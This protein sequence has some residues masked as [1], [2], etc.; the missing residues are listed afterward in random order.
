VANPIEE[1]RAAGQSVWLDFIRRGLIRSGE[2]QRMVRA[3]WVQGV[4]S[5]PTIFQKAIAGSTDYDAAFKR[6]AEDKLSPYE[7]FLEIGGEDI[8]MAADVLRPVYDETGGGDG[9]VSFEAQAG[10]TE[11]MLAEARRMWQVVGRPNVMIKIPGVPEGVA[12]VEELVFE[13][14]NVNITLLFDVEVYERFAEAYIRGLERRLEAGRRPDTIASVAS[15]FVSRV[16]AKVDKLLPEGSPLR[17]KVAIA[18]ARRAYRRFLDRFY[19]PR[20]ERLAQTGALVQRPLWASTGTK[21]PEYSD[22]MYVEELVAPDTVNTMPEATLQAFLD[23]GKVRPAVLEGLDDA[24][25]VLRQ[26]EAAGIDL[27]KI[28]G[29]LL[30]EGLAS[31]KADF[32][33]LLAEIEKA[34]REE[35][36]ELAAT[37]GSVVAG[38]DLSIALAARTA[39]LERAEVIARIWRC[40]HRVWKQ[41]PTEITQPNRLGWLT[42]MDQMADELDD[43]QRFAGEVRSDGLKTAVVL[44]MGGSSLAPEVLHATFG[45]KNGGLELRVLDT[46]VPEDILALEREIDPDRTLFIVASKSGTTLET[47][48]QFAYFWDRLPKGRHYV[49][50][51]DPGTP[52]DSLAREKGFRRTFLN[53]DCLGGRHSALSYVGLVP[54]ALIGADLETLIDGAQEMRHACHYCVPATENPGAWLG[55]ILGEAAPRG[56]DKLT[57]VLPDEVASLGDWIEQLI[58]ESTGKEGKGIVPVVGE[59]LGPP[60]V[61]GPDRLFVSLGDNAALQ[62]L[63]AAGHPVVRLPYHGPEQLGAE[64]FRWMF[65]TAVAGHI[66]RINPFDQ[67]DVQRAKDAAARML[68]EGPLE[69]PQTRSVL[70][71]LQLIRPG[72]YA[73][74]LAYLP[75]RAEVRERLDA[76]RLKLRDRFH[77]ATTVGFGPRYLHSTGQLHKGG[78][79]TGVFFQLLDDDKEDAPIP[80]RPY[81]FA[82]LKRAQADGDLDA[83]LALGRRAA[84]TKLEHLEEA[85]R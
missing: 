24:E 53:P 46:T 6:L 22:V 65:A 51:T 76:L 37:R 77:I 62:P 50:I 28:G 66:L 56:Q 42:I 49:A 68:E 83:L 48:S 63:E 14:I 35:A 4:T 79:N 67:P 9:F 55:A 73:A 19:G 29:E 17:G 2:L 12:A 36:L 78:P 10:T 13:G 16:D 54:A 59:R 32:D 61:Y 69:Q 52:L 58:A 26:A 84:R 1:L 47:Q 3:G 8:R 21:N 43:L 15:F 18:N 74:L 27:Q 23:H 80:G 71:L 33:K 31:F 70:E 45:A 34:L 85:L 7:A 5:N 81:S 75:R 25:E 20:W 40:D 11:D 38:P 30:E 64:F 57:L 60:E 39:E 44:G 82:R 41:D 72:H